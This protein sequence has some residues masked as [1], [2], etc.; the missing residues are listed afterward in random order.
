M[1]DLNDKHVHEKKVFHLSHSV[2]DADAEHARCSTGLLCH[3]LG[4]LGI[5]LI[6]LPI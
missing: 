1:N 5:Q 6:R 2:I 3:R 4:N